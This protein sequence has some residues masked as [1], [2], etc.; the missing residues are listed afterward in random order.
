MTGMISE[1]RLFLAMIVIVQAFLITLM[2][3]SH[4]R[5]S[6]MASAL[7][8]TE[9]RYR[10]IVDSQHEMV[11]RYRTD[12]TL[13]FVNQAYCR[14][15]AKTSEELCGLSLFS[16][17]PEPF[18]ASTADAI[19]RAAQG[20]RIEQE[21]QVIQPGGTIGWH[22]W[23]DH[24]IYNEQGEVVEMQAIGRD[25]TK[26]RVALE[27]LRQSEDRLSRIFR[28]SPVPISLIRKAD[29]CYLEVNPSW[30]EF[31]EAEAACVIGFN[32][33]ELG[34]LGERE[35]ARDFVEF[36]KAASSV[37]GLEHQIHTLKGN[38]RWSSIH[39]DLT[40][41][42][43]EECFIVTHKDITHR[44]E[45]E[46]AKMQLEQTTK[47]AM[48]GELTAS[49]AHELN[50]PLGAIL[51]NAETAE[52]LLRKEAPPLDEIG[53][54]LADIRR[55]DLRA[56]Q[57]IRK[58]RGMVANRDML[59]MP[60]DVNEML[61][62][63][64][65]LTAHDIQRRAIKLHHELADPLPLV[66]GD[67]LQLEQIVLN[68]LLNAIDAM[69]EVPPR[70]R[71]IVMRSHLLVDDRIEINV[72]DS[73]PGI[74]PEHI[75]NIFDSFFTTKNTGMG[76]GLALSRSIAEAHGGRLTAENNPHG[77]ATFRLTL[78]LTTY[79]T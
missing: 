14:F 75:S 21:H 7:R 55:D 48:L 39:C 27:A 63:V 71:W 31:F 69:H 79:Q 56:S 50:Q 40:T 30:E 19:R 28:G 77:G 74:Q 26:R 58:V 43:D 5:R 61:R 53:Q 49:I 59:K 45:A 41:L 72:E 68:L 24:P 6:R 9:A 60:M 37:S 62:E 66:E 10:E 70:N 78:P 23:E 54:I 52:M 3:L 1:T 16:L 64:E 42:G 11:C 17:I 57:I 67:W 8:L 65:T 4:F 73:G 22:L 29:G 47:L 13:T 2:V 46:Q 35:N 18:H 20:E 33:I 44:R 36:V 76:L 38:V 15:F 32:P 12:G 25:I 34:I 51:S